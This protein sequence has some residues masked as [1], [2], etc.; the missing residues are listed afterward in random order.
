MQRCGHHLQDE[1][2]HDNKD[3]R[4][5][6]EGLESFFMTQLI[7]TESAGSSVVVVVF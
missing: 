6:V 1:Y 7:N 4:P 3:G 2:P 5:Q